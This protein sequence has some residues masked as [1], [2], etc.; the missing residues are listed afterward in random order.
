MVGRTLPVHP[1]PVK[2]YKIS[3]ILLFQLAWFACVLGAA[4]DFEWAGTSLAVAVAALHV[5]TA[6]HPRHEAYLCLSAAGLGLVVDSFLMNSGFIAFERGVMFPNVAPHWMIALWLVFATT[7]NVSL[8]WLKERY[9]LAALLGF[10]GGPL[11]YYAGEKLGAVAIS[12]D[13]G[14]LSVAVSWAV[15]MP[16]LCFLARRF[17]RAGISGKLR[18]APYVV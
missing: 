1:A 10:F 6:Q 2:M 5:F 14:M 15:A 7:L 9:L 18:E 13:T 4:W 11:A 12:G 8:S 16:A 17:E 3:N